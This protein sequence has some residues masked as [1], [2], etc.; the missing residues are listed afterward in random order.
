[1]DD[2]V[3]RPVSARNYNQINESINLALRGARPRIHP[4]ARAY[5]LCD[6]KKPPGDPGVSRWDWLRSETEDCPERPGFLPFLPLFFPNADHQPS[7]EQIF[8]A[9]ALGHRLTGIA[10]LIDQESVAELGSSRWA[11]N[12]ALVR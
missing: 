6:D 5:T 8:H 2:R 1:M 4:R 9:V 11:S 12:R 3:S 10:G 7:S